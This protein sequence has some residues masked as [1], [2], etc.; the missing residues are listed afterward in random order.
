MYNEHSF[1][2]SLFLLEELVREKTR[3]RN[4]EFIEDKVR[5][6]TYNIRDLRFGHCPSVHPSSRF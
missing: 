3:Q 4:S 1:N 2:V 5:Q 6:E